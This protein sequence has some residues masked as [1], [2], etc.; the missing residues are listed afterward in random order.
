MAGQCIRIAD[1]IGGA[2]VDRQS[3][4]IET[5]AAAAEQR[6]AEYLA[7]DHLEVDSEQFDHDLEDS[8]QR[9]H[10]IETWPGLERQRNGEEVLDF[11]I[12]IGNPYANSTH[13]FFYERPGMGRKAP[14]GCAYSVV[15][16]D[17]ELAKLIYGFS[18]I[19]KN[20]TFSARKSSVLGKIVRTEVE[21]DTG[22]WTC[23]VS[24]P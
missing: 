22:S 10:R 23:K 20:F 24:L 4:A 7:K 15:S 12:Q 16:L 9:L 11:L 21:S 18:H 14:N 13:T 6:G 2:L 17:Q 5:R 8:W 3:D 19:S 1:M